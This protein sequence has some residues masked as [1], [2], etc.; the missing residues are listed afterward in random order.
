MRSFIFFVKGN[1]TLY[2]GKEGG[3]NKEK[4]EIENIKIKK[5]KK[6]NANWPSVHS[7]SIGR[8]ILKIRSISN[9]KAATRTR[10]GR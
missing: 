5:E 1:L 6:E 4:R 3:N 2:L 7:K 8:K 10:T 9:T